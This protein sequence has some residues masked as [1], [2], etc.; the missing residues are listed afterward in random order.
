MS[1]RRSARIAWQLAPDATLD[2]MP[3]AVADGVVIALGRGDETELRRVALDDGATV[4]AE[5][6][7]GRAAGPPV[8]TGDV[9]A[10]PLAG[11]RVSVHGLRDGAPLAAWDASGAHCGPIGAFR[12]AIFV[13]SQDTRGPRLSR[14]ED[15]EVRWTC[16]D[17]LG[18]C[19]GGQMRATDGAL[20]IAGATAPGRVVAAG[21]D[22][23]DG[24]ALWRH[25]EP[26]TLL[27]D[28]WAVGGIVDVVMNTCVRGLDART[29]EARP[30]RFSGFP[31]DMARAVGEHLV[32]MM[33]GH[34]GPV[35][36]CFHL[37][38]QQHLGRVTRA[39]SRLVGA[40]AEEA[41]VILDSGDAVFY[42]LP[43]L[44]PLDFPEPGALGAPQHVVWAQHA[45]YVV[46][47]DGR[48]LTAIDLDVAPAG[49]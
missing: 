48:T 34:T 30:V 47:D 42:A 36:L 25:E 19:D 29:G 11:G 40:H 22:L 17:P 38:S 7:S 35:L 41:L 37:V 27:N 26:A 24:R 3:L 43:E 39:M 10:V 5:R 8:R 32:A 2:A 4:W 18:G 6:L 12:G 49:A 20:V 23:E 44:E 1:G 45:C 15:G 31:L 33:S 28:L 21:V 16:P 13:R 46:S 14:V 9:L